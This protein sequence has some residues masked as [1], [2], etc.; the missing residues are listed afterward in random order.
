MSA[1]KLGPEAR[2]IGGALRFGTFADSEMAGAETE[3][4]AGATQAVTWADPTLIKL[5]TGTRRDIGVSD[6]EIG[7]SNLKLKPL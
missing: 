4:N 6:H 7:N 3:A 2:S 5:E 1:V